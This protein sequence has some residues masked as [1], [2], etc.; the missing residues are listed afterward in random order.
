[1]GKQ[2]NI[3]QVWTWVSPV[4]HSSLLSRPSFLKVCVVGEGKN[5]GDGSFL[6]LIL[7]EEPQGTRERHTRA[8]DGED[9]ACYAKHLTYRDREDSLVPSAKPECRNMSS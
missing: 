6:D 7:Q 4:S 8:E 9:T 1:V 5:S 2:C 3:G